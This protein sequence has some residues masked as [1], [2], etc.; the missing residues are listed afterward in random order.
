[1]LVLPE[2][3]EE[4]K[5]GISKLVV[6]LLQPLMVVNFAVAFHSV[7]GRFARDPYKSHDDRENQ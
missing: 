4:W 6:M 1:M 7:P 2:S 3:G 5:R